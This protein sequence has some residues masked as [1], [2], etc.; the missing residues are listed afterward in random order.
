MQLLVVA[1]ILAGS[2]AAVLDGSTIAP[3][4]AIAAAL[5]LGG[6]AVVAA[7]RA[8]TRRDRVLDLI[9]DG[10]E[11]L[12]I[13][14]VQRQRRRLASAKVRRGLARTLDSMVQETLGP[15]TLA[16]RSPRPMLFRPAIMAAHADVRELIELL[17]GR[18]ATVRGVA[19]TECLVTRGDSALYGHDTAA[20]RDALRRARA[21]LELG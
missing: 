3:S 12:P 5:V 4:V 6:F 20:L 21:L 16:L 15:R 8:Q 1:A 19:F 18:Q 17:R 10:Q 2:I 14:L 11:D 9:L 13:A 7:T